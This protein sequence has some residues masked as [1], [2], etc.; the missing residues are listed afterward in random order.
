VL[1]L[2]D[3]VDFLH[4]RLLEEGQKADEPEPKP[5]ERTKIASSHWGG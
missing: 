4:Q 5:K 3:L 1:P 2:E